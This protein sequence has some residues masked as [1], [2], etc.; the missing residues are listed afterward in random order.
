MLFVSNVFL[1]GQTIANSS[2]SA[3]FK[4]AVAAADNKDYNT[5]IELFQQILNKWPDD[6]DAMTQMGLCMMTTNS[7]MDSVLVLFNRVLS[8]IPPETVFSP[9]GIDLQIAL[10]QAHNL[11]YEPEK[12]LELLSV[13]RDSV[14][15]ESIRSEIVHQMVQTRNA[16]VLLKN[17]VPLKISNLGISI[18]SGF[19]DH[20]P[21]V[22][23]TDNRIF[24]TSRRPA[25]ND[26]KLI[27]GQFP[28]KVFFADFK[29]GEWK[30]P[31][32][33]KE[34]FSRTRHKSILSLSPDGT[35]IFL[36][37]ND[38]L[39]KSIYES[40][41]VNG[42]WQEPVSLPTPINSEWDETHASLSPDQSTLYFTSNRP[43]GFGGLDIYLIRKDAYG[44]WMEPVNLGPAINTEKDEETPMLHPDG[45]TLYFSSQGHSSMGGAD[46]FY[47]QLQSDGTWA[48]AVN[49]GYPINSPD[50]DFFFVPTLDKSQAFFASYRFSQNQGRTDLYKVDFDS[51]FV[52][53][54]AVIEGTIK[55]EHNLPAEHIRIL[56]S[57]QSDNQQVGDFRPNPATGKYLLF[58]ETGENYIIKEATPDTVLTENMVHIREELAYQA[59]N[60]V[61]MMEDFRMLSPLIPEKLPL[62]DNK[63]MEEESIENITQAPQ[64]AIEVNSHKT[65]YT[66]QILALKQHPKAA[67]WYFKGLNP[68]QI[69]SHKGDDGYLRYLIGEFENLQEAKK[70]LS[71]IKKSGRFKDAWIRDLQPFQENALQKSLAYTTN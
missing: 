64:M 38:N 65:Q 18:N 61:I 41:F 6:I 56:V 29:N 9:F 52:G 2:Y 20:S 62:V 51:T 50:D 8:I 25:G 34:F 12:A 27:D 49:M 31:R 48:Q 59:S 39:G 53:S 46:V 37:E 19:D 1:Q 40:Q 33:V 24:F 15:D 14:T 36:F 28:E 68:Q 30:S 22:S 47:S 4:K 5:A 58:L 44:K 55:N 42:Q 35:R 17:P 7:N 69:K 70:F 67:S 45:K 16:A 26:R 10:A 57:R 71:Q 13:L 23:F 43:G 60:K 63:S 32:L 11:N 3:A 66:V 21:L 54:L